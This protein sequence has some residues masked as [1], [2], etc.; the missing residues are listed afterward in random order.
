[1]GINPLDGFVQVVRRGI[2]E[3]GEDIALVGSVLLPHVG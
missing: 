1:M 3:E 2:A